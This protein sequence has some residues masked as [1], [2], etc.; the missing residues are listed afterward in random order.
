MSLI[1]KVHEMYKDDKVTID[2]LGACEK[3]LDELGANV[4]DIER[5]RL[6]NF[7]TWYLD[8]IEN[9]LGITEKE[10]TFEKRCDT[11]RVKLLTRGRV[12]I[13]N[14]LEMCKNY[15][16]NAKVAYNAKEFTINITLSKDITAGNLNKLK[17]EVRAY[18]PAHILIN[19]AE[20]AR[21]HGELKAF[22]H[23]ELSK[24]THEEIREKGVLE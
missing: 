21:T 2:I 3:I 12:S 4:T 22:T 19:Y 6:L 9:E 14:V 16:V 1:D 17:N 20:Y 11:V 24:Y 18:V 8:Q 13:D 5:Q 23:Q 15:A 10:S 7:S